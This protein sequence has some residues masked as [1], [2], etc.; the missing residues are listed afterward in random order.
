MTREPGSQELEGRHREY[1]GNML[2]AALGTMQ[3]SEAASKYSID[4]PGEVDDEDSTKLADL[5]VAS[6][7]GDVG[8]ARQFA[9]EL[10]DTQNPDEIADRLKAQNIAGLVIEKI[11]K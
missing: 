8:Q 10:Y 2:D 1:I 11:E 9:D 7:D 5:L 6:F 3:G 4:Y